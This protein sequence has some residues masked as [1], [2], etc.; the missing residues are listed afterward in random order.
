MKRK[1]SIFLS[2]CFLV[3]L[4]GA[5]G[6]KATETGQ[7]QSNVLRVASWDEYIDMGGEDSYYSDDARPLYEEFEDWYKAT[8]G[9]TI[10]VEYIALQDNETMYSKIKM[11]DTYDLLCPSEYMIMKLATEDKLKPKMM[12][13]KF[14]GI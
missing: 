2:T 5:S 14:N 13:P 4:F 6:C 7:R 11:G 8:Y 12:C 10:K 9:K 3:S 1:L